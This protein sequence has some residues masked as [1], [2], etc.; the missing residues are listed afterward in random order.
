MLGTVGVIFLIPLT[1][2]VYVFKIFSRDKGP[3]FYSQL[4]LGKNGKAFKIYKFRSMVEGADEKLKTYLENN[5]K[6]AEYYKKYKK[7]KYDPRVTKMG[8]FL[9]ETSLDE[10]PQFFNI[11]IG[12]M[13]LVGPR[14]YLPR[15]EEDMGE[16]AC[17]RILKVKPGLTG[18]WQVAGRSNLEFK[19]R[20]LLD[21]EYIPNAGIT[22]DLKIALKTVGKVVKKEGVA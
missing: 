6:E 20:V 22:T 11:L 18:P 10:W 15:E 4:R 12:Q 1:A 16:Y 2:I 19:D 17:D 13:S 9:R 3:L 14:P 7:L 21:L 5:P 8:K